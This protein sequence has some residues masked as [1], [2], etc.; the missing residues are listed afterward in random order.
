MHWSKSID[1]DA[2]FPKSFISLDDIHTH[3][4]MLMLDIINATPFSQEKTVQYN[5]HGEHIWVVGIKGTYQV[6]PDGT[7]ELSKQQEAICAYPEY[8]GDAGKSTLKRDAELV[9]YHPGTDII[10]NGTAHAPRGE[11]AKMVDVGVSVGPVRRVFRVFGERRWESGLFG[12]NMSPPKPFTCLPI[13]Y[14][15]AYGG[16]ISDNNI[17]T[18]NPIGQ[19]F[20]DKK[21]ALKDACLPQVEDPLHFIDAWTDKPAPAGF[22]AIPSQ[23][24]PRKELAGTVDAKWKKSR[25]PLLPEDFDP[26]FFNSTTPD[27]RTEKPLTGGEEVLLW[28]LTPREKISFNLPKVFFN[29]RS[30]IRGQLVRNAVQL[31][32]VILEPDESRLVMVW[33]T[34]V[35]MGRD[36]RRLEH[37]YIDTK[38]DV[39]T[40]KRYGA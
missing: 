8:F 21:E 3:V 7:L 20:A 18:A 34:T 6:N 23:W 35:N 31:D 39:K 19:G 26:K 33:R 37:T 12:L 16:K 29:V 4:C 24:T 25:A 1:Q 5:E 13:D 14:E 11:P 40:G 30:K 9:L 22:S 15:H 38:I 27:M 32:R 2:A 28:N 17:F 36:V 10:V